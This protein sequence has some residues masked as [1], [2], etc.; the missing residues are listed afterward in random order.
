MDER[1]CLRHLAPVAASARDQHTTWLLV[2]AHLPGQPFTLLR[3]FWLLTGAQALVTKKVIAAFKTSVLWWRVKEASLNKDRKSL[4]TPWSR[5]EVTDIY[6]FL[7]YIP[8]SVTTVTQYTFLPSL[9]LMLIQGGFSSDFRWCLSYSVSQQYWR[10][11]WCLVKLTRTGKHLHFRCRSIPQ[12]QSKVVTSRWGMTTAQSLCVQLLWKCWIFK[13]QPSQKSHPP[14][15]GALEHQALKV[16][17]I[18]CSR[19]GAEKR[20]KGMRGLQVLVLKSLPAWKTALT[21]NRDHRVSALI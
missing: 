20:G 3:H 7:G 13:R 9:Q 21:F 19:A 14:K 12:E 2:A 10:D 17:P 6:L 11:S 4:Q 16:L 5:Y 18:L 15:F 1:Y 8:L